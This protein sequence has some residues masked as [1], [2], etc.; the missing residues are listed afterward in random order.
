[1]SRGTLI[2]SAGSPQCDVEALSATALRLSA[3]KSLSEMAVNGSLPVDGM[4]IFL[5]AVG[6][7][8]DRPKR[9]NISGRWPFASRMRPQGR[10]ASTSSRSRR[11][12]AMMSSGRLSMC[13]AS[14][15][16]RAPAV[17]G[18]IWRALEAPMPEESR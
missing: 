8:E 15:D 14:R 16:S 13:R 11:W 9:P 7:L 10:C 12:P 3:L 6:K 4:F 2:E 18:L 5:H 1:M 17:R